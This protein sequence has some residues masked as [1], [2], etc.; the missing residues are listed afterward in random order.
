[1][2]QRGMQPARSAS[3]YAQLMPMLVTINAIKQLFFKTKEE[4]G[5]GCLGETRVLCGFSKELWARAV[6]PQFRQRPAKRLQA[7]PASPP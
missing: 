1:M 3:L 6:R 7:V 2:A 4:S 5:S